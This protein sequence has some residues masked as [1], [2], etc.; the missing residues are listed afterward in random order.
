MIFLP[1]CFDYVG[2]SR[3]ESLEMSDTDEGVIL[4]RYRQLAKKL[5]VWLSLGGMH[6]KVRSIIEHTMKIEKVKFTC[7]YILSCKCYLTC[8][9]TELA[10]F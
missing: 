3:A 10:S 6:E 7:S 8:K 9:P 1:E 5:G 2:T 4:T